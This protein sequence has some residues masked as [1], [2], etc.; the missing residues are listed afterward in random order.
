MW[1]YECRH[2]AVSS[3]WLDTSVFAVTVSGKWYVKE[4]GRQWGRDGG[5]VL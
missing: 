5:R 1:L 3:G 4:E 2:A